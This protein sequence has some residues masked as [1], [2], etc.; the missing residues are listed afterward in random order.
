MMAGGSGERFWPLSRR[1]RPKQLL[2]LSDSQRSLLSDA[3]L[4]VEPLFGADHIYLST[5]RDLE[6]LL[7]GEGRPI[8]AEP[9]KRNT[10]GALV[11]SIA[12]LVAEL[13][14]N[15]SIAIL[16]SDQA[17]RPGQAFRENITAALETAEETGQLGTIG[18][19]P[20]RPATGFGYVEIDPSS[21]VG[22]SGA[23][24]VSRFIEKPNE[25]TA[26]RMVSSANFLW[27]SG[28]FFWTAAAFRT[29]LALHSP[30]HSSAFDKILNAVRAGDHEAAEKAFLELPDI[31]IDYALMERAKDVFVVESTFEWDDLGSWDAL[32]RRDGNGGSNFAV[33]DTTLIDTSNCVVWSETGQKVC[34]LGVEDLVLVVT[35]DAILLIPKSR[36]QDVRKVLAEVRETNPELT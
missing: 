28:M 25:E 4:R 26:V 29:A 36:S 8:L 23:R 5:T 35:E 2:K 24:R 17:V 22:P 12:H 9:A 30:P 27:N 34:A 3:I 21:S 20:S 16:T 6:P 1:K 10:A 13:G 7:R 33:G 32:G 19:R 15:I 14:E 31:S 18:V 11:W